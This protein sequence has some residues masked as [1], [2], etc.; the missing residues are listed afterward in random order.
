[1]S[2]LQQDSL[3]ELPNGVR[4]VTLPMPRL[5]TA[6]VSVFVRS[7]SAHESRAQS[8]I[9]HVIEHMVFKGTD[10]GH[11]PRDAR[12]INLDA[13]RLGAEVN[14][15]TDKDH[16]AFH[17]RGLAADVPAF[18][19]MLG[20]LV[21]HPSFP[22]QELEPEREVLLQEFAETEDDPMAIAFQL[23]DKACF[24][25]H[26]VAQPVI[27]SRRNIE[28]FT[29]D[30]LAGHVARLYSGANIVVAAAGAVQAD[31]VQQ[32][33]QAAFGGAQRGTPNRVAD[34]AWVG[35]T[36]A[37]RL[38]GSSQAHLV[39]G[40]PIPPLSAHDATA[41][42]AAAVLGEGMS[43]PLMDQVR[44]QRGLA[45][46]TACSADV[47]DVCGQFVIEASTAP[48]KLDELLRVVAQLLRQ[49]AGRVDPVDLDRARQ[50]LAVRCA[51]DQDRPMRRLEDAA[52]QV[53]V[54]GRLR[55]PAEELARLQAVS[56]GEV[57]AL[58]A[59]MLAAPP[60]LAATGRLGRATAEHLRQAWAAAV[61]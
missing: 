61:A 37:R 34:A 50:Q 38:A 24:G 21:R 20:E 22:A 31:A 6:A 49:H 58:F 19:L 52:M 25:L 43:S 23:F 48:D 26:P 54:H 11:T 41:T 55:D 10:D 7:G 4:V 30:D 2:E 12:R 45:Y 33:A 16:T 40:F 60:A 57:S 13:E 14:A 5:H 8:G 15:H 42:V 3:A 17:M 35:G 1:M 9:G 28:R 53:F 47:L 39:L 51:R 18:V 59:R 32:A 46:Y 44:E 29:R 56:A 36:R 27:G